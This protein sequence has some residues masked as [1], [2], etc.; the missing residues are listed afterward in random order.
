VFVLEL[1][2]GADL[3]DLAVVLLEVVLLL[4]VG[5]LLVTLDAEELLLATP[6]VLDEVLLVAL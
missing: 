5:V 6:L 2:D 1:L 4:L 3:L